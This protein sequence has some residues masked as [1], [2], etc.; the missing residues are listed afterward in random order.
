[1]WS[2]ASGP[3][4]ALRGRR[5]AKRGGNPTAGPLLGAPLERMVRRPLA[6]NHRFESFHADQTSPLYPTSIRRHRLC[7]SLA[8]QRGTTCPRT[9]RRFRLS[10]DPDVPRQRDHLCLPDLS[11]MESRCSALPPWTAFAYHCALL[12]GAR[13]KQI[14]PPFA[15]AARL[16]SVFR[17]APPASEPRRGDVSVG[18]G[19]SA[20]HYDPASAR[21]N[22]RRTTGHFATAATTGSGARPCIPETRPLS[23]PPQ[24]AERPR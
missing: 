21:R 5:R 6:K 18:A 20:S 1:M 19:E 14:P 22:P 4:F 15:T 9:P 2:P 10:A 3:T 7:C 11:S 24:D 23:A 12:I 13:R 17:D 8:G 16:V